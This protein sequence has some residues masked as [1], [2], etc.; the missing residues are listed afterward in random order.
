MKVLIRPASAADTNAIAL[1][2]D[3]VQ[4][5]HAELE[6][7][8]FKTDTSHAEVAAF[9]A[10]K[11]SAAGHEIQLAE[12]GGTPVGYVW[13][14]VQD[15]PETAFQLARKRIYIHHLSVTKTARRTG[16]GSA[17]LNAIQTAAMGAGITS[18][19]L[20]TWAANSHALRFFEVHGFAPFNLVLGKRLSR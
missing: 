10:A 19:A 6:P 4:Q 15:R 12:I 20:D 8:F 2:N 5:L 17:L 3:E 1:L 13:F 14:E 16:V 11:L 18:I 9:F 7:T